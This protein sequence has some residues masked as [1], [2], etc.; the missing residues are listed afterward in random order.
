MGKNKMNDEI[1]RRVDSSSWDYEIA[2]Y[3]IKEK[4]QKKEK[5][6]F[7]GAAFSLATAALAAVIFLFDLNRPLSTNGL[8]AGSNNAIENLYESSNDTFIAELDLIINE[9][10]PMR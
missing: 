4:N 5:N 9:A 1:S 8:Y 3:V 7:S 2:S 6:L 10:Y